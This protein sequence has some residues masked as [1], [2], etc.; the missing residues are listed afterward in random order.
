MIKG[1][2]GCLPIDVEVA[3]RGG[4]LQT[5]AM[6]TMHFKDDQCS[7]ELVCYILGYY[8]L[9]SKIFVRFSGCKVYC[10]LEPLNGCLMNE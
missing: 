2:W 6:Q 4:W 10:E 9:H 7:I 5:K 1:L 3:L 8:G